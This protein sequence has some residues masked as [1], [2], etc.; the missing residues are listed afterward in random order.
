MFIIINF[1]G[2]ALEKDNLLLLYKL[3]KLSMSIPSFKLTNNRYRFSCKSNATF[4]AHIFTPTTGRPQ[5]ND[6]FHAK[7]YN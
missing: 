3:H 2:C 5:T 1:K 4:E 6:I 7:K